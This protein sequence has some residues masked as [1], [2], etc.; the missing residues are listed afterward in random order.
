MTLILNVID[1]SCHQFKGTLMK[2]KLPLALRSA[3]LVGAVVGLLGASTPVAWAQDVPPAQS[4]YSLTAGAYNAPVYEGSKERRTG[5]FL[6]PDIQWANGFGIGLNGLTYAISRDPQLSYGISLSPSSSR[7]EGRAQALKGMGNINTQAELG[8][9][10]NYAL[11]P[12][13]ALSSTLKYGAGNDHKGLVWNLGADYRTEL[14]PGWGVGLGVGASLANS[15]YM[16]SYFGVNAAQSAS[17]GYALYTPGAGLKDINAHIALSHQLTKDI[18]LFTQ[19]S[20]S[21]LLGDARKSP[22]TLQR[23]A[24]SVA[25]GLTY[26]F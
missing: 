24:L 6:L 14:A 13:I 26:S 3:A 16:Q 22:L 25:A 9:Y 20:A 23:N 15:A 5:A 11:S 21:T 1:K 2:T 8:G 17:S 10:L 4:R 7:L 12:N 19:V 18:G